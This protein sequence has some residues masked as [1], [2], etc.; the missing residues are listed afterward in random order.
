MQI[1]LQKKNE[2][3][4]IYTR[5]SVEI[6]IFIRRQ[7]NPILCIYIHNTYECG[8]ILA[9]QKEIRWREL[10]TLLDK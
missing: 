7:N 4:T 1:I 8:Y 5:A 3:R 9:N 10:L 2:T 6:I